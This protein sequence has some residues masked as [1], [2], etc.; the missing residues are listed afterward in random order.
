MLHK[1]RASKGQILEFIKE[2]AISERF[3]YT[4][5][6]ADRPPFLPGGPGLRAARMGCGRPAQD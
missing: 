2:K 6:D 4:C 1:Q 5:Q 3:G